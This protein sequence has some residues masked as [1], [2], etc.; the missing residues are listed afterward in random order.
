MKKMTPLVALI[1]LAIILLTISFIEPFYLSDSN[2]F[3]KE[4]VNHEFLAILGF[5]VAL[6]LGSAGNIH[7]ELN[8]LED[9]TDKPFT[10]TRTAIKKSAVSLV[11]A[12]FAAGIL[13]IFKPLLIQKP[14][15]SAVANSM[16]ILIV[17]FNLAVLYDLAETV[18]AIPTVKKIKELTGDN[19]S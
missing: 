15:F 8:R 3:L 2:G 16:A 18:F 5:I 1:V 6:T 11:I 4:F 19:T 17:F 10:R 9:K 14:I 12:F 7:L 13:V